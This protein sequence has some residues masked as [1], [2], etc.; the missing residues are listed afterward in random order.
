YTEEGDAVQ[1][2][3]N[4]VDFTKFD[5]IYGNSVTF[6]SGTWPNSSDNSSC[7]LGYFTETIASVGENATVG[8]RIGM[9]TENVT[10]TVRGMLDELGQMGMTTIDGSIFINDTAYR[11][12]LNPDSVSTI[13]VQVSDPNLAEGIAEIISDYFD[14]QASVM[15]PSMMIE[16]MLSVFDSVENFLLLIAMMALLVAGISIL[17]IML[18][19]VMERTREI[20]ILKALGAKGRT[21]LAQFLGEAT[22]LG[23]VGGILGIFFGWGLGYLLIQILPFGMMF[24]GRTATTTLLPVITWDTILTALVFAVVVS[25][26]FALYPA[27]KAA[28][29]DPVKAL[30][31]E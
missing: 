22:I 12:L 2:M 15:V 7:V 31:Y 23:L 13:I 9:A 14:G 27:R 6:T 16:T 10:F 18:V 30:R 19:S 1:T 11:S 3:L 5:Q 4:G 8:V 24:G 29:L 25:V 28:R 20:G 26:V 17:N 21:I